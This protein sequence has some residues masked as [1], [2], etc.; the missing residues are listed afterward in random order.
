VY[1]KYADYINM[2]NRTK[3]EWEEAI[4]E[5]FDKQTADLHTQVVDAEQ[6]RKKTI[7][8]HEHSDI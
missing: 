7:Q 4:K 2:V 5:H 1:T 3:R 6:A 8:L